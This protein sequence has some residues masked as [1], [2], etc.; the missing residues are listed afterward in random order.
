MQQVALKEVRLQKIQIETV[1]KE[2]L[3]LLKKDNLQVLIVEIILLLQTLQEVLLQKKILIDKQQ[4]LDLH[5]KHQEDKTNLQLTKK[6]TYWVAFF[7]LN[8]FKK[9]TF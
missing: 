6:A 9:K 1:L 5:Q 2:I 3:L 8:N 7:R 4:V